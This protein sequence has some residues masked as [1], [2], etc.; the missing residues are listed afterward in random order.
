MTNEYN[1]T[2]RDVIEFFNAYGDLWHSGKTNLAY[3]NFFDGIEDKSYNEVLMLLDSQLLKQ[4]KIFNEDD[5]SLE[6]FLNGALHG[7]VTCRAK[8]LFESLGS[9]YNY[10]N[11]ADFFDAFTLSDE[12]YIKKMEKLSG[13]RREKYTPKEMLDYQVRNFGLARVSSTQSISIE[14]FD[15]ETALPLPGT[16][17]EKIHR[18]WKEFFRLIVESFKIWY[19]RI[20][21][22]SVEV[23]YQTK[24]PD[25]DHFYGDEDYEVV[26]EVTTNN[27]RFLVLLD[28]VA[29]SYSCAFK[30]A[31][32]CE[33]IPKTVIEYKKIVD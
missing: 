2:Y 30:G 32:K 24:L 14:Q 21:I 1:A 26:V 25:Y 15:P 18:Q 12:D 28:G 9:D 13:W 4:S 17:A 23:V 19:N 6:E 31:Y 29:T 11:P 7:R 27:H 20:G 33:G 5:F 8:M 16:N 10:R 3:A 22:E